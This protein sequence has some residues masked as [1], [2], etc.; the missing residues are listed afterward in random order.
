MLSIRPSMSP[1]ISQSSFLA[2]A[3]SACLALTL[4]VSTALPARSQSAEHS[5][6]HPQDQGHSHGEHGGHAAHG[7]QADLHAPGFHRDFSDADRWSKVFDA[8]ERVDWQKPEEVVRL[9][10]I[11]PGM[12]VV[13]LG[14]GTGFFLGPLSEAVG[15]NG[16]ARGLD[17]AQELVDHMTARAESQGWTNV[18]AHV[19]PTNDPQL[20]AASVDR[21]LIVNVWHH[22]DDRPNYSAKLAS[23]LKEGGRIYVVDYTLESPQGP[24]KAHRL[25]A[26][27]VIAELKA[28][29]F[30]AH[31][32][33]EALPRQYVVMAT[34]AR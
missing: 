6:D 9:M 20:E 29:G 23:A 15:E 26:E 24:P 12:T 4:A 8:P 3:L 28:A 19:I 25:P 21:V 1:S 27:R 22:L 18:T 2:V 17:I 13:D 32:V 10:A 16:H 7:D 14:A 31:I 30:E 33:D 5:S 11:E 34:V